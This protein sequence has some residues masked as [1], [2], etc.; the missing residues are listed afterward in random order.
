MGVW[1]LIALF[2]L[3]GSPA[4]AE[5][6][7]IYGTRAGEVAYDADPFGGN[8]FASAVVAALGDAGEDGAFAIEVTTG[9]LSG[10]YQIADASQ[11][12][13]LTLRLAPAEDAVALVVVFADY[14]DLAGLPS[15][16]GAAFDAMRVAN[17]LRGAGYTVAMAVPA[18]A[19]EYRGA[20]AEFAAASANYDRALIYTTGHG[21]E[22]DG[23]AFLLPPDVDALA[24]P[25]P[26]DAIGLDEVGQSLRASGTNLLLYAGCRENLM[27]HEAAQAVRTRR[28]R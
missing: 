6:V 17:A 19:A 9:E 4:M 27:P 14:G 23:Y 12:G 8:P 11:L 25:G 26:G 2:A 21:I 18:N 20:L 22:P 24:N 7:T 5:P 15:L 28:L 1:R 3:A 16:P 10:G 13:E